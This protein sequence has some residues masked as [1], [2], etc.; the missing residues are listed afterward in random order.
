MHLNC[1]C[2]S[3]LRTCSI[4]DKSYNACTYMHLNEPVLLSANGCISNWSKWFDPIA[5]GFCNVLYHVRMLQPCAWKG[6]CTKNMSSHVP[7]CSHRNH[8]FLSMHMVLLKLQMQQHNFKQEMG[9]CLAIRCSMGTRC[10]WMF[11][12]QRPSSTVEPKKVQKRVVV[13]S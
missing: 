3:S 2:L 9:F 8:A 1:V 5:I 4:S 10:N 11:Q 13:S 6:K 7:S 12:P